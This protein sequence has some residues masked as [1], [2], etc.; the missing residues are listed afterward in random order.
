ML[1]MKSRSKPMR[2]MNYMAVAALMVASTAAG[3]PSRA[4]GAPLAAED[5][6]PQHDATVS[7]TDAAREREIERRSLGRRKAASD[8]RIP[9]EAVPAQPVTGEVPGTVLA[10]LKADLAQ[11]L[12]IAV[13]AAIVVRAEQV[14][15][16]DGALG[17]GQPGGIYTEATVPGYLVEFELAGHH[18]RY[19]GSLA[20]PFVYCEHPWPYVKRLGP[21][22]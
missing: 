8:L 18:Y 16:P 2:S 20:G 9:Q 11:R 6:P 15:W 17:C 22:Q 3:V 7:A 10:A 5:S 4:A 1:T 14:I 19:H 13:D 12:A 21:S